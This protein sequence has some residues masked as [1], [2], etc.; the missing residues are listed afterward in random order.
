V[1]IN[2]DKGWSDRREFVGTLVNTHEELRSAFDRLL[3]LYRVQDRLEVP[4]VVK[5]ATATKPHR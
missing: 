1:S 3:Q 2:R 4:A 5:L